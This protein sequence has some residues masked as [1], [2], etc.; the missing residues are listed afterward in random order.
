MIESSVRS[1]R[2]VEEVLTLLDEGPHEAA[3]VVQHKSAAM[4]AVATQEGQQQVELMKAEEE[5]DI[6]A[7][8]V[9]GV[10]KRVRH[11]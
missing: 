1:A 5:A 6:S 2:E 7:E 3:L 11:E 8:D 9:G 10:E 4:A